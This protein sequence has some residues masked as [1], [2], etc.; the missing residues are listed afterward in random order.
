MAQSIK[1]RVVLLVEDEWLVRMEMADALSTAGWEVIEAGSGEAALAV[2]ATGRAID[3]LVTDVRLG[4]TTT[5]WDV[6]DAAI[7]AFPGVPV[8]YSSAN[9]RDGARMIQGSVFLDKPARTER[10]LSICAGL[11]TR[12]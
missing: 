4:G 8:L 9:P 2:L 7:A 5:G 6:A 11:V 3:L 1:N 12:N 10:L